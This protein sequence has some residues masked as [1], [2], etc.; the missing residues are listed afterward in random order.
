VRF[1][2]LLL[3]AVALLLPLALPVLASALPTEDATAVCAAPLGNAAESLRLAPVAW[4]PPC[5]AAMLVGPAS[6]LVSAVHDARP[7]PAPAPAAVESSR[8]L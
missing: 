4:S 2:G 6:S 3:V 8:L 5:P 7:T 1:L